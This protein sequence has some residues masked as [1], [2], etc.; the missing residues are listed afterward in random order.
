MTNGCVQINHTLGVDYEHI[1][2]LEKI[3]ITGIK[4]YIFK[5]NRFKKNFN[6]RDSLL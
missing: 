6:K 1:V 3:D 2:E 5:K 4:Y